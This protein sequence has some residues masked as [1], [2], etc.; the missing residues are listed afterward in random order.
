MDRCALLQSAGFSEA[1][2]ESGG[3]GD[4]KDSP[5][6]MASQEEQAAKKI[7]AWKMPT[8]RMKKRMKRNKILIKE[9]LW[10]SLWKLVNIAYLEESSMLGI[11]LS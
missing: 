7:S 1:V 3:E 4:S 6:A 5:E 10:P 2:R 11:Q 9:S 8:R